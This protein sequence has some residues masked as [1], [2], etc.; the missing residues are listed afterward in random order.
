MPKKNLVRCGGGGGVTGNVLHIVNLYFDSS[1]LINKQYTNKRTDQTCSPKLHRVA[2]T[3]KLRHTHFR[4]LRSFINDQGFENGNRC[5]HVC[6][7][8]FLIFK[9]WALCLSLTHLLEVV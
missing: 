8:S 2:H 9:R 3:N 6:F 4:T 5:G 1:N 7:S